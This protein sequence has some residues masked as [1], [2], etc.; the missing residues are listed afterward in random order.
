MERQHSVPILLPANSA[1]AYPLKLAA[2]RDGGDAVSEA[3]IQKLVQEHP[4][5]LPV[6]EIDPMFSGAV[7]I[8]R[9]L[10]TPAG[11]I[12]NFFVTPSGLPILVE[13]KLWRNPEARREVVA[14]I[15]D[16]A[17]ELSRWSSAD[18]QREV[19]SRLKSDG[20]PLL[21]KVRTVDPAVEEH[22]FHDALTANLRRGRFLLLIVGDG[23]R[24]GVETIIEYL[25]RH[26]GLHFSLGLVEMPVYSMPNGDQLVAPR[27][28]ARTL[29]VTRNVVAAPEGYSVAPTEGD[30][31]V[32]IRLWRSGPRKRVSAILER[33]SKKLE[34]GGPGAANGDAN[35]DIQYQIP[36]FGPG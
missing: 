19:R 18:L 34:A 24:E 14:Q 30:E 25:Q 27:V 8:C 26:A 28:L 5:C 10:N 9:E 33:F 4:E 12:D 13:C 31:G 29:L 7:P 11:L 6:A 22:R 20:D 15:L 3:F 17:K 2:E 32:E 23:I 21:D 35:Q 36:A 16:Y 1:G